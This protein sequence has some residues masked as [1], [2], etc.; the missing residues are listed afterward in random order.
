MEDIAK[1][2]TD[3][4]RSGCPAKMESERHYM[5]EHLKNPPRQYRPASFWLW[6]E[7]PNIVEAKRQLREMQAK[8]IGGFFIE[9]KLIGHEAQSKDSLIAATQEICESAKE[10]G[11]NVYQYDQLAQHRINEPML[12]DKMSSS[13]AHLNAENRVMARVPLKADWSMSLSELKRSIDLQGCLGANFFCADAFYYSIAGANRQFAPPSQF[14]QATYWEHY[15]H[16]TDYAARLGFVLSQGKHSAQVLV[17]RPGAYSERLDAGVTGWLH[18]LCRV[19]HS[20]HI[21]FDIID[22]DKL[23]AAMCADER[24]AVADEAYE[25][26]VLPPMQAIRRRSA[27]KISAFVDEGGKVIGIQQ[28]P[29]L[30]SSEGEHSLIRGIF[31]SVFDPEINASTVHF[32]DID[33]VADL[34]ETLNQAFILSLKRNVSIKQ[35]GVECSDIIFTH[36]FTKDADIFFL[37][38][39]S[40]RTREV[41]IS[42]RCDRAPYL[43][44]L[45]TGTCMALP[46]CT[47]QGS[48]TILLHRFEAHSSLMMAF[49]DEPAL[50]VSRPVVE[51]G[52][53]IAV[54]DEWEFSVQQPNC[55]TLDDWAFNTLIQNDC[56]LFEYTTTFKANYIPRDLRLALEQTSGFKTDSGLDLSINGQPVRIDNDWLVDINFKTVD[57]GA[58]SRQGS[59]VV[60]MIVHRDG[61]TGDP[62]PTPA[63][64]RVMGDFSVTESGAL[65]HSKSSMK[66][67]SWTD[68][69]YPY[70]SG[71]AVYRQDIHIAAFAQGQRIVLRADGVRDM[72]E[73]VI[74]GAVAGLRPWPPYEMDITALVRPGPNEIELRVTNSLSNMLQNRPIPSGLIEGVTAYLA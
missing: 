44:D 60:R 53:E 38:N 35:G 10:T 30:D 6:N 56:E 2:Y 1:L 9:G 17:L 40:Q 58:F 20:E 45:E 63:R 71:T 39:Q 22:E 62:I 55:L 74:N 11:L 13:F 15:K 52:Q 31:D 18:A 57:I 41:K 69:G 50:A 51:V 67:G 37:S 29:T 25:V 66:N 36:R 16:L 7:I 14:Y 46:N 32:L 28:L 3:V 47:Q 68:Q 49:A 5:F 21:D 59:N 70:Y 8:G 65:E 64:A 72:V 61:W 42:V 12:R 27:E 43:L 73:F 33:G 4:Q 48:R 34:P 24:L 23:A 54:S 19:M 26:L